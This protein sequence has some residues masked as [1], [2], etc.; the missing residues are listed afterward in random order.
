M[1]NF[2]ELGTLRISLASSTADF[3]PPTVLL[4][5]FWIFLIAYL[6]MTLQ[7]TLLVAR[8]GRGVEVPIWI[9]AIVL[10]PFIG[11]IGAAA[12]YKTR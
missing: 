9:F 6:V 7:A 11:A 2:L 4:A 3:D 12:H 1:S 10:L 5:G 8:R